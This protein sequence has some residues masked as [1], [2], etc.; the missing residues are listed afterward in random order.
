MLT[1][2]SVFVIDRSVLVWMVSNEFHEVFDA[3]AGAAYN[4]IGFMY[5]WYICSFVLIDSGLFALMIGKNI[6]LA[7]FALF[8]VCLTCFANFNCLSMCTPRY[9]MSW[10][11]LIF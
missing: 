4:I 7:A 3:Q 5:I 1:N 10:D 11:Q 2:R 9:L 8:T 6:L